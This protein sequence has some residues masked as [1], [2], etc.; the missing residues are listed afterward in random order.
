MT[1]DGFRLQAK[2]VSLF[3]DDCALQVEYM[4]ESLSNIPGIQYIIC[5]K[6]KVDDTRDCRRVVIIFTK[7]PN[8]KKANL[9]DIKVH[10]SENNEVIMKTFSATITTVKATLIDSVIKGLM[11]PKGDAAEITP[12]KDF[13]EHGKW[14][15][16]QPLQMVTSGPKFNKQYVE[17][18]LADESKDYVDF[19]FLCHTHNVNS[20]ITESLA[21]FYFPPSLDNS[22]NILPVRKRKRD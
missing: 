12:G 18:F 13:A 1:N 17:E 3:Y 14:D 15:F 20:Y 22:D 19:L 21:D 10:V 7:A 2:Y 11:E 9:F 5:S 8:I 16:Q 4:V 6:E